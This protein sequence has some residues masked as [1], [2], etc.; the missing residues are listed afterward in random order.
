[1]CD[2]RRGADRNAVPAGG[3]AASAC[4]CRSGRP[5]STRRR[6]GSRCCWSCHGVGAA[7][8]LA[9]RP[10]AGGAGAG[11]VAAGG[12]VAVSGAA[13]A[14]RTWL[15]A[16]RRTGARVGLAVA[17]VAPLWGRDLGRTPLFTG[18]W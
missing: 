12:G 3:G 18:A 15:A 11:D 6:A 7:A 17:S 1:V 10:G 14:A 2:P 8:A 13:G 5:S 16:A 9:A 4:S